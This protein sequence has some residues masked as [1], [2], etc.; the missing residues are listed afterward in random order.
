MNE[1]GK[2]VLFNAA[3]VCV[4]VYGEGEMI[5]MIRMGVI[6][7][8][9]FTT[10]RH[11]PDIEASNDVELT[12]ICRRDKDALAK[13]QQTF[14]AKTVWTDWREMLN[15]C[16]LDAV[17]I[18]TPHNLH[19]EPAKASLER[20][21][22]T[23]I[24]KP[25]SIHT[26]EADELCH[27][28]SEKKLQLG[29]ALNPPFWAHTHHIRN[30]IREGRIGQLEALSMFWMGNAAY[31]FGQAP[32]PENLPG[33]IPPTMYRSD[34]VLCGG[35]YLI[36]GG[37]HLISEMLWTSEHKVKEVHCLMDNLPSDRRAELTLR[38]ENGVIG[39]ITCIGDSRYQKRRV[40]NMFAG[41][42]GNVKV[43]DFE[44][45]V[46]IESMKHEVE[47]FREDDLKPVKGPIDNFVDAIL[48][49]AMLFSSG[50]HGRDVVQVVE[51]AYRSAKEGKSILIN[52]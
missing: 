26:N 3:I 23:L 1:Y 5:K 29:V 30:V 11:L 47:F 48:H 14:H 19:F 40:F 13:I 20:G 8:G 52:S 41:D 22:H 18:A 12:A 46:M 33:L 9:W 31:V 37:S 6:G 4:G 44:F 35:G 36:D 2:R 32:K 16:E 27:M 21:L 15:N 25:M 39:S 43:E 51:A 7:A 10:R 42:G 38:M 17:L 50:E 45:N 24:E 49:R 34:P 28:A